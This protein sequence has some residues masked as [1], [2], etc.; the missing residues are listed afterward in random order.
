MIGI[1]WSS[2]C[3][4]IL[5]LIVMIKAV[6]YHGL[7]VLN[8]VARLSLVEHDLSLWDQYLLLLLLISCLK[9]SLLLKLH[10]DNFVFQNLIGRYIIIV[11]KYLLSPEARIRS[12]E[13]I[14][15][16]GHTLINLVD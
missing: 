6:H 15:L 5:C 7:L 9:V 3:R 4:Y 13:S 8:L 11:M 14:L 12:T 2:P 16:V 10:L 1:D